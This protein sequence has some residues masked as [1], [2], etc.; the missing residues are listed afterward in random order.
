MFCEAVEGVW[1]SVEEVDS[2]VCGCVY[3]HAVRAGDHLHLAL[4]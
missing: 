1:P 3:V 4:V 2:V